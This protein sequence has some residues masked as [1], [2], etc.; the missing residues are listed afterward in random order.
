M[1]HFHL[2]PFSNQVAKGLIYVRHRLQRTMPA[3]PGCTTGMIGLGS[4]GDGDAKGRMIPPRGSLEA[5]AVEL[6]VGRSEV[7]VWNSWR[8]I[9]M[10]VQSTKGVSGAGA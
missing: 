10:E 8:G 6:E 2:R 5:D 1:L 9:W 7:V 4:S 3:D